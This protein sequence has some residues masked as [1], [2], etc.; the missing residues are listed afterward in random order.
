MKKELEEGYYS[1]EK[2]AK[3][4]NKYMKDYDSNKESS[5]INGTSIIYIVG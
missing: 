4:Y 1:I 5:Y 3:A 2:Y